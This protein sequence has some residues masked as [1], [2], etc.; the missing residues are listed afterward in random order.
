MLKKQFI[1]FLLQLEI[2]TNYLLNSKCLLTIQVQ[3]VVQHSL[4]PELAPGQNLEKCT[5]VY[6]TLTFIGSSKNLL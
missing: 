2:L 3:L 5:E 6:S 4:S 1:T